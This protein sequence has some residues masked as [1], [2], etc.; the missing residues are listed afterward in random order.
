MLGAWMTGCATTGGPSG[1]N[2]D[3]D[4][5]KR[6]AVT[7]TQSDRGAVI[8][9]DER[10]LFDTGKS[11]IKKDGSVFIDRVAKLLNEKTSANVS[12]EGHTDNVGDTGMNQKLSEARARSVR[13]ALIAKGVKKDR[14]VMRGHGMTKPV[15]DNGTAEGRQANRR[16]EIIVLGENAEKLGGDSLADQLSAGLDRFLKNAGEVFNSVFGSN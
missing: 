4:A 6:K 15:A 7:V 12:V 5:S 13:D 8:T 11:N 14:I 9:S 10:V 3:Y 1:E 16:T 2:P